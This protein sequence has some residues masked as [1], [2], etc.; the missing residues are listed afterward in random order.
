MSG[1]GRGSAGRGANVRPIRLG[2]AQSLLGRRERRT[3]HVREPVLRE[4]RYGGRRTRLSPPGARRLTLDDRGRCP[5]LQ[6]IRDT[7]TTCPSRRV[8]RARSG[9]SGCWPAQHPGAHQ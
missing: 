2:G 9:L 6:L 3:L 4:M 7:L 8:L 1:P 5:L